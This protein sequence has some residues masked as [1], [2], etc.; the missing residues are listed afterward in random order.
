MWGQSPSAVRRAKL[1]ATELYPA[2]RSSFFAGFRKRGFVI[3]LKRQRPRGGLD[4]L[5]FR[6]V[7]RH[8]RPQFGELAGRDQ[9]AVF[10]RSNR[11][12]V[13][14]D[15][16][17]Q[18]G[19]DP[20]DVSGQLAQAVVQFLAQSADLLRIARQLLLVPSVG[21]GLQQT[22]S[23]S[24]AMRESLCCRTPCSISPGSCSSAAL[25]NVSPGRNITTNSGVASNCSQ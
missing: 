9:H 4:G 14:F 5:Q 6:N 2:L 24:W 23:R 25:K 11:L 3:P 7:L 15:R 21:D 1:D 13:G 22:R 12:V 17:V 10:K 19:A 8:R 18:V 16:A 20:G